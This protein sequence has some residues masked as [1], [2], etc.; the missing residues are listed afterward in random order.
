MH[1]ARPIVRNCI[2][3]SGT[4]WDV[5]S[6]MQFESHFAIVVTS[7]F[8]AFSLKKSFPCLAFYDHFNVDSRT[9]NYANVL[10]SF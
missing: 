3:E 5:Q 1:I 10:L 7:E 8:L 9:Q 6:G 2:L 4:T